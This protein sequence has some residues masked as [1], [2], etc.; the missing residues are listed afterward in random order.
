[1]FL[2]IFHHSAWTAE[3]CSV[4]I[5][6]EN[7]TDDHV[8]ISELLVSWSYFIRIMASYFGLEELIMCCAISSLARMLARITHSIPIFWESIG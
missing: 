5:S 1:M 2:M 8:M 7:V 4:H 6:V 3:F